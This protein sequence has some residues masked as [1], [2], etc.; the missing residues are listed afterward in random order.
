MLKLTLWPII[1]GIYS[2]VSGL[3]H[4][5][6]VPIHFHYESEIF[7]IQYNSLPKVDAKSRMHMKIAHILC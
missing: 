4:M 5:Y 2:L 1:S 6:E 7:K 3:W